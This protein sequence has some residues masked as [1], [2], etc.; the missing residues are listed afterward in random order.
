MCYAILNILLAVRTIEGTRV[1]LL[2]C[3]KLK[4]CLLINFILLLCKQ[5]N[6]LKRRGMFV[7][8]WA[9][10]TE[11]TV[12]VHLSKRLILFIN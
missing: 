7:S 4:V 11:L 12:I 10:L 6:N 1:I 8:K 9:C 5:P 2:S 3:S